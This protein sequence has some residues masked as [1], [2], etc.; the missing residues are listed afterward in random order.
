MIC[1]IKYFIMKR[2]RSLQIAVYIVFAALF[3]QNVAPGFYKGF[4]DGINGDVDKAGVVTTVIPGAA[5][6]PR[7][8][9]G[10]RDGNMQLNNN[11]SL[12]DI[13]INAYVR[14][15]AKFINTP[16]WLSVL[17]IILTFACFIILAGIAYIINKVIYSIY[18]GSIFETKNLEMIRQTGLLLIVF[19]IVDY[20]L[21]QADFYLSKSLINSPVIILRSSAYDF[22]VLICGL[23]VLIVAEAFKQGALLKEEQELTI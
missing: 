11:Y 16:S 20:A 6:D 8:V 23:L 1:I 10:V 5:I 22:E 14:V 7:L 9:P 12:E 3:F 4:M 17:N 13:S 18:E 19:T 15:D 21:E 2:V